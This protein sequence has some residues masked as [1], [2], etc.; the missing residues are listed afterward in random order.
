MLKCCKSVFNPGFVVSAKPAVS[1]ASSVLLEN[2]KATFSD[3]YDLPTEVTE[4]LAKQGL[5]YPTDVQKKVATFFECGGI[6][7]VLHMWLAG[8]ASNSFTLPYSL[9]SSATIEMPLSKP[10]TTL[11]P[12]LFLGGA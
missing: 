12:E 6:L 10:S 5:L 1:V 2:Q 4:N 11:L 8:L 3:L 7:R 9:Y